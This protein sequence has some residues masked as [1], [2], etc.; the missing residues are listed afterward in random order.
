M[1]IFV[2]LSI[3]MQPSIVANL[4]ILSTIIMES[5]TGSG[6]YPIGPSLL[7]R[8]LQLKLERNRKK[9]SLIKIDD[10]R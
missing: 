10:Q 7:R 3:H 8:R 2:C 5:R 4:V 6:F 9:Y 1:T